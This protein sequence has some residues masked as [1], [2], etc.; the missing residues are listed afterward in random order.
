MKEANQKSYR[1]TRSCRTDPLLKTLRTVKN[2]CGKGFK[3]HGQF[4]RHCWSALCLFCRLESDS[5]SKNV[6]NSNSSLWN[7]HFHTE[8]FIWN[9]LFFRCLF[10][11]SQR[12][13]KISASPEVGIKDTVD[14]FREKLERLRQNC[15]SQVEVFARNLLRKEG[16]FY[17]QFHQIFCIIVKLFLCIHCREMRTVQK[18]IFC[19]KKIILWLTMLTALAEKNS[20][21]TKLVTFTF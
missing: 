17:C 11:T 6:L 21:V 10:G 4:L 3:A 5:R 14:R 16:Y 18:L 8:S 20:G 19:Y 13:C 12:K 1:A 2:I 7:T 15:P 9:Y